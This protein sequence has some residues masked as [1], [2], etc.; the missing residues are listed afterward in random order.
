[1]SPGEICSCECDDCA[2]L[3]D[4]AGTVAQVSGSENARLLAILKD[5]Q[6]EMSKN[7]KRKSKPCD[8]DTG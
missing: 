6:N 4:C 2:P 3:D 5:I 1:M 7:Q 8:L